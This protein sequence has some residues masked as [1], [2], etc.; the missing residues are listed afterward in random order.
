MS[1]LPKESYLA[2]VAVGWVDKQLQRVEVTGLMRAAKEAGLPA[3]DLSAIEAATK[4]PMDL[5]ALDF[6]ALG[7]WEQVLTYALAAWIAQVDGVVSTSESDMLAELGTKLGLAEPLRKRAAVAANDIACLPEGGRPDK[8]D[9]EK[10]I[11]RLKERMPQ[12]AK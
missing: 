10:L 7:P 3:Q 9:F 4:A 8:Y 11:A 1:T 5:G 6:S 12:L 2:L